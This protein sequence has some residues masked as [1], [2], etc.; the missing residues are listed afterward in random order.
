MFLFP[1]IDNK[2]QVTIKTVL[3]FPRPD[4]STNTA[5]AILGVDDRGNSNLL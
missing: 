1:E 2:C 5:R 4:T 3:N